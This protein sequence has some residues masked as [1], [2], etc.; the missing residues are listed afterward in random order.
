MI[1]FHGFVE[2]HRQV[3]AILAECS[4]GIA[5]YLTDVGSFTQFADPGKLKAYLGAGLP[6]VVTPV[7]PIAKELAESG[8]A[9]IVESSPESVADGIEAVLSSAVDWQRRRDA[10]LRLTQ[11][12]DWEVILGD[13]LGSLGFTS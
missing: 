1:R 8:A 3:E 11:R 4:V 2:D 6:I 13:A 12:Y 5:P 9:L 10:A 7:P